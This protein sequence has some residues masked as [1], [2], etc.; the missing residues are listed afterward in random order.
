MRPV[1][2]ICRPGM[3]PVM[4][5]PSVRKKIVNSSGMNRRPSFSP[6]VSMTM[7]LRTKPVMNS[8]ATW[9][10]PGTSFMLR[11]PSQKISDEHDDDEHPDDQDAVHLER[12][13]DEEDRLGEELVDRRTAELTGGTLRR[14]C[15]REQR[16]RLERGL[17]LAGLSPDQGATTRR[18]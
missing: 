17:R 12:G 15:S 13:A 2:A 4:F 8:N 3:M 16:E 18:S 14:D 11:V 9:P 10:R 7:L 5:S 6:S 1:L